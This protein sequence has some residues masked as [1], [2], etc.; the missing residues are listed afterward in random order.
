[1]AFP[2]RMHSS[3]NRIDHRQR[4]RPAEAQSRL[5]RPRPEGPR[6]RRIFEGTH[7]RRSDGDDAMPRLLRPPDVLDRGGRNLIALRQRQT[8]VEMGVPRRR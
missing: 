6:Q 4:M 2:R 3:H 5:P 1:M 8:R 7:H